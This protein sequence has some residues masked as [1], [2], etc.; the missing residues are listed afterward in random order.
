MPSGHDEEVPIAPGA[1]IEVWCPSL[2][3]WSRGF[4]LASWTGDR[5]AIRRSSDPDAGVL[6]ELFSNADVRID[7]GL[8][9]S[10]HPTEGLSGQAR[11]S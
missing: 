1:A 7:H 10:Q 4:E 8:R 9:R 3:R 5:C 6:P 11:V 2:Q